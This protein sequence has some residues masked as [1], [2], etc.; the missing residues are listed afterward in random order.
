MQNK[1]IVKLIITICMTIAI[2]FSFNLMTYASMVD[3]ID[4]PEYYPT[5]EKNISEGTSIFS[6]KIGYLLGAINVVGIVISVITLMI[7][8]IR[9]MF[10]SIEEKAEY[11][12]T[13]TMYII[14]AILLFSVTTIPN[15]LYNIGI[16]INK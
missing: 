6:E 13:F 11:K 3:P 14:G 12:Q 15:I 1:K 4:H 5:D 8:G 16:S 7:L 10:G 2:L 9:Y